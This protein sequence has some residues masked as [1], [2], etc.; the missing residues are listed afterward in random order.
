APSPPPP[1]RDLPSLSRDALAAV[2]TTGLGAAGE[3]PE[4][5]VG[6]LPTSRSVAGITAASGG[7]CG[8]VDRCLRASPLTLTVVVAALVCLQDQ[9]TRELPV[10]RLLAGYVVSEP[11]P[12][13]V[14]LGP[15]A[16]GT[17][18]RERVSGREHATTVPDGV[19]GAWSVRI[20]P[21]RS[22]HR[23]VVLVGHLRPEGGAAKDRQEQAAATA[24]STQTAAGTVL[25][26]VAHAL[27]D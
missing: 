19:G 12:V 16:V 22:G 8:D 10:P 6:A 13:P 17:L 24:R 26:K 25:D 14:S 18:G 3:P 7:D 1:A 21:K 20:L 11:K 2:L 5:L 9:S 27:D 23:Q 15:T 4:G